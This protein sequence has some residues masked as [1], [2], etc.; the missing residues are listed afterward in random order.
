MMLVASKSTYKKIRV[1]NLSSGSWGL[2]HTFVITHGRGTIQDGMVNSTALSK[3]GLTLYAFFKN[4]LLTAGINIGIITRAT[5]EDVFTAATV[6]LASQPTI[7]FGT[8]IT[9]TSIDMQISGDG[10]VM[11]L[12]VPTE[13]R[14]FRIPDTIVAGDTW[15]EIENYNGTYVGQALGVTLDGKHVAT[16]DNLKGGVKVYTKAPPPS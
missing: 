10:K 3:D 2:H 16:R 6:S 1:Y 14:A 15:E 9:T 12:A 4:P 5:I 7:K 11:Y 13:I 8:N